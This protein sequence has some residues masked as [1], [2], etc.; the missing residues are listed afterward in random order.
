MKAI[1]KKELE[2]I[3]KKHDLWLKGDPK[4]ERADL[5]GADLSGANLWRANL[6]GANL[7]GANLS[8]AN[9]RSANLIGANLSGANLIGANLIGADLRSAD[10]SGANLR[11]VKNV[12]YPIVCP[13]KGSFIGFKKAGSGPKYIVELEILEDA[14]R[15]SATGR[16]CRCS[17][18]KVLSITNLDGTDSGLTTIESGWDESFKYTVGEIVSV[19][20]FDTDRWNECAPGIHFFITREEAVRY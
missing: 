10:L 17:K 13:E 8:G 4:G 14:L 6:I 20:N 15:S 11:D 5:S 3:L 9:L 19:D 18:A 2:K 12:F 1:T 7:I 16:K